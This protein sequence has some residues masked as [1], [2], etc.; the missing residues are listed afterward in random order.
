MAFTKTSSLENV[1]VLDIKGSSTRR[2]ASL[3]KLS[4]FADFRTE[5]GYLYARIRAISSRV[6]KNHDGW[7]SVE[8]AGGSDIF[9][10]VAGIK[11]GH[12]VLSADK[13]ARFGY[14]TFVGK[15]IFVDH[16]NGDP[17]RARG[18]IVDSKLHVED[19]D[20]PYYKTAADNHKPPTWV[21]LL[22]EVDAKSFPKL[23]TAL[24]EGSQDPSKGIDGFS[25]GCD[26][27]YSKC[28]HCGNKASSPDQYCEHV[29][30][31][32][33][34]FPFLNPKTGKTESKKS[35]EDCYEIGFFEISAVFDPADETALL[36]EIRAHTAARN[37]YDPNDPAYDQ[38][39]AEQLQTEMDK[40][41]RR[42]HWPEDLDNGQFS[43]QNG[44]TPCPTCGNSGR[45]EAPG[46]QLGW[47]P[48]PNCEEGGRLAYDFPPQ[49]M[50]VPGRIT[51]GE[52]YAT[53]H[54][55]GPED[56]TLQP[57]NQEYDGPRYYGSTHTANQYVQPAGGGKYKIVQKGTGK[58]LSTHDSKEQAEAAFR[59][60]EMHK[61]E[62]AEHTAEA[63]PP[64]VDELKMPEGVD[65]LRE[66]TI[67]PV[68]GSDMDDET[69]QVCG[70]TKPP[71]GFDNPDLTKANPDITQEQG[72]EEKPSSPPDETFGPEP[73][74]ETP[75]GM[76]TSN[77]GVTSHVTNDEMSWTVET[78][79]TART[80]PS[81]ETPAIPGAKPATDEPRKSTVKQDHKKPVTSSNVRTAE[82]FLAAA[83]AQRRTM[84]HTA[85]AAS[86]APEVATP[87]K[88]IDVDGVGGIIE[89][90]NEEA[91]KAD[92]QIDVVG[93]GTTGTSDV[94]ADKTESVDQGDEHSKNVEEIPTKTWGIGTGVEDQI[95]GVTPQV[96]PAEGGVTSSWQ[97]TA[98][99]NDPYPHEDGG[100]A[101]GGANEGT[102]PADP[103]GKADERVDLLDTVTSPENNSG[104]TKTWSGT[105]GNGVTKQ[106]D[107]V[108]N[109]VY[110]GDENVNLS[111]GTTSSAHI[112]TAMK[113]ADREVE[114]GLTGATEK[115]ERAAELENL[116]PEA[117]QA[118]ARVVARVK[119]AGLAKPATQAMRMPAMARK[120]SVE[121]EAK[122]SAV[123]EFAH[124]SALFLP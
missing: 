74:G 113:L 10:R 122:E 73:T 81:K 93:V 89:P 4:E 79:H 8:L 20:D 32:G 50:N 92:A 59:A 123:S 110:R 35:Y 45:L 75:A 19:D 78:T 3:D 68:C 41:V 85:E 33:A 91:S 51:Q 117:L 63:P 22:L 105:D 124:D 40:G 83:D 101:G 108:T 90:S 56:M 13:D 95:D 100:L 5:D 52:G 7:P 55:L 42:N 87:D 2:Q 106:Q 116:S 38:M 86:G 120:A 97:I 102:Q 66:E 61:H 27:R 109:E 53:P 64:Q 60:M 57:A 76:D 36:R 107:P 94:A 96:Y 25:M 46:T 11:T 77:T 12:V 1:E 14:S 9:N 111:P 30:L 80:A 58:T 103:V 28:S 84:E 18:V 118:E 82:D 65:T 48:C 121:K 17:K 114:L 88:N 70:Y 67:C 62:G 112:F 71:D 49:G 24:I 31:K 99:D 23:A 43:S 26:V 29:R 37:P 104:E 98:L 47:E 34:E 119:N 54:Q 115:Y 39:A 69:C 6:N 44:E 16:H 72:A 21:E 15:P